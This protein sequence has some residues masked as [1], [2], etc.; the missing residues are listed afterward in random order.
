M[1]KKRAHRYNIRVIH[2]ALKNGWKAFYRLPSELEFRPV[3]DEKRSIAIFTTP[4]AARDAA[5]RARMG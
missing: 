1:R 5:R 3:R 2:S 4:E